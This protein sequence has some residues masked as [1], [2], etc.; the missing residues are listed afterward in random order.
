MRVAREWQ[1]RT[2][3]VEAVDGAYVLDGVRYASLSQAARAITGVRWNG[4]RFFG[5][6]EA[7]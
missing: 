4:P 7:A 1:G 2:Y 5:L 3:Q 6:R